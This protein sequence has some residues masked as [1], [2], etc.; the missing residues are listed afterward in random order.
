MIHFRGICPGCNRLSLVDINSPCPNI[1]NNGSDLRLPFDDELGRRQQLFRKKHNK[2]SNPPP[3][4]STAD[5]SWTSSGLS[6][7]HQTA[8]LSSG[9]LGYDTVNNYFCLT[10]PIASGE[11]QMTYQRRDDGG[12]LVSDNAVEL[13]VAEA[14]SPLPR[15]RLRGDPHS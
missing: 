7:V 15:E 10:L 12:C 1:L 9:M 5:H 11:A 14:A 3:S 6:D 8:A 2:H 13:K 4:G